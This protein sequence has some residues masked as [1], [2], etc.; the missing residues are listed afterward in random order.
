MI[1]IRTTTEELVSESHQDRCRWLSG[2]HGAVEVA[3]ARFAEELGFET[4]HGAGCAFGGKWRIGDDE[5]ED[6]GGETGTEMVVDQRNNEGGSPAVEE[7]K[8]DRED[9]IGCA[10][11]DGWEDEWVGEGKSKDF[12]I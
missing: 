4:E 5:D 2:R 11:A 1:I 3:A 6:M 7:A 12:W 8:E 9:G 10:S